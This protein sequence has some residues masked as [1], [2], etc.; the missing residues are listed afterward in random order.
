MGCEN[1][2][3]TGGAGF[4]GSHLAD[5]LIDLG[6]DVT[7]TEGPQSAACADPDEHGPLPIADDFRRDYGAEICFIGSWSPGRE[8]LLDRLT[9]YDLKIYGTGWEAAAHRLRPHT[10][11]EPV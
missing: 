4:I 6:H 8:R 11:T 5:V 7:V 1:V 9:R 2:L 10:R 3:I